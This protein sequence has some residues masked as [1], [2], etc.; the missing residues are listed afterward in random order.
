MSPGGD[1]ALPLRGAHARP[2]VTLDIYEQPA[3]TLDAVINWSPVPNW[4][5]KFAGKNLTRVGGVQMQG[6]RIVEESDGSRSFGVSVAF[7]S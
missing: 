4:R 3:T 1:A 2:S 7:G 5:L 6:D